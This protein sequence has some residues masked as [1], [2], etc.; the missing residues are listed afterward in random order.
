MPIIKIEEGKTIFSERHEEFQEEFQEKMWLLMILKVA[1]IQS[2][3]HFS[4]CIFFE[5]YSS[6]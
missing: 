3:T 1:K 4:D 2:F 5:I 6:G